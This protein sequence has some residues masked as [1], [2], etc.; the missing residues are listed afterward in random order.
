MKFKR[1]SRLV[2][3]SLVS[4]QML[5]EF[6]GVEALCSVQN[7]C[8]IFRMYLFPIH[9]NRILLYIV[10]HY[11]RCRRTRLS[12]HCV[13]VVHSPASPR[14]IFAPLLHFAPTGVLDSLLRSNP[15]SLCHLPSCIAP[16]ASSLCLPRT[17]R[18]RCLPILDLPLEVYIR[19]PEE[20][21]LS[22]GLGVLAGESDAVISVYIGVP[23]LC[24]V[25]ERELQPAR[26]HLRC[27]DVPGGAALDDP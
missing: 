6:T 12:N 13:L 20:P 8:F 2:S 9:A 7:V 26:A 15:L 16:R 17:R 4:Q 11:P 14:L 27:E 21:H 1:M 3:L 25:G 22:I 10:L 19:E 24:A 18:P 23:A 5:L